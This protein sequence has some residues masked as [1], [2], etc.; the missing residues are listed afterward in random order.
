MRYRFVVS[1]KPASSVHILES[2]RLGLDFSNLLLNSLGVVLKGPVECIVDLLFF[3]K[4]GHLLHEVL[5]VALQE[6]LEVLLITLV[7]HRL[8]IVQ[9]LN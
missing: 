4:V 2:L 6:L 7:F 5:L 1:M 8:K 9:V 3:V